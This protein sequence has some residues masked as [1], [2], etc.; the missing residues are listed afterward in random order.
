V[1][2][3]ALDLFG[4]PRLLQ[5]GSELRF[6]DRRSIA[7]LAVLAIDGRVS[8]ARLAALLWDEQSEGDAR[9]N[10]RRPS[11]IQKGTE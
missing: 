11:R 3:Y 6:P 1:S 8:R 5:R 10:L 2:E 9:R 7:L 4:P